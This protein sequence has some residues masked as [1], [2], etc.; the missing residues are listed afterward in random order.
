VSTSSCRGC[1]HSRSALAPTRRRKWG[2]LVTGQHLA[3]VR[4]YVDLGVR[5]GAKLVDGRGL[6]LQG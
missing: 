4:S 5:E 1:A 6:K 2:P 3:K